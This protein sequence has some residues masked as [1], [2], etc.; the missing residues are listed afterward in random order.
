MVVVIGVVV[1]AGVG[2]VGVV[3]VVVVGALEGVAVDRGLDLELLEERP[4]SFLKAFI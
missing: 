3:V 1:I 2:F 4:S